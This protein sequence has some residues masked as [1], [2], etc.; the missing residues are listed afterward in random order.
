MARVHCEDL[1]EPWF[2]EPLFCDGIW[3]ENALAQIE[4]AQ[5]LAIEYKDF[6]CH[7][8]GHDKGKSILKGGKH[9]YQFE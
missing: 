4:A 7:Y 6:R 8:K 1:Y 9:Y 2:H 3:L 5:K